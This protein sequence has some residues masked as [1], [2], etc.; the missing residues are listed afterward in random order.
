MCDAARVLADLGTGARAALALTGLRVPA[1]LLPGAVLPV[2]VTV[3]NVG[4]TVTPPDHLEVE[5]E[6]GTQR[7]RWSLGALPTLA[8]GAGVTLAGAWPLVVPPGAPR[9]TARLAVVRRGGPLEDAREAALVVTPEAEPHLTVRAVSLHPMHP[10]EAVAARLRLEND[11][12]VPLAR[13]SGRRKSCSWTPFTRAS[14][15][16]PTSR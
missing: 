8:P 6:L 15:T 3:H 7:W 11:G 10:T 1:Y 2:Q 14:T 4:N 12:N 13:S 16:W 9:A 5:G